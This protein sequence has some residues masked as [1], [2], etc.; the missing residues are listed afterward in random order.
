MKMADENGSGTDWGSLISLLAG[1]AGGLLSG[2]SLTGK[3]SEMTPNT[4]PLTPE[5]QRIMDEYVKTL[6][7]TPRMK[8]YR[9]GNVSST[10]PDRSRLGIL[11]N[12]MLLEQIRKGGLTQKPAE[13]GILGKLAPLLA[14]LGGKKQNTNDPYN[15]G[16][17]QYDAG[18]VGYDP[19]YKP[20]NDNWWMNSFGTDSGE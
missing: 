15:L 13:A 19:N 1:A 6:D 20:N 8:T 4:A 14:S 18:T 17:P 16:V 9:M 11:K 10:M 12:M 5:G 2:Q 3:Q 7:A